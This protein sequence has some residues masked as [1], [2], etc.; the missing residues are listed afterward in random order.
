MMLE[1][2]SLATKGDRGTIVSIGPGIVNTNDFGEK[3]LCR[4]KLENGE[5]TECFNKRFRFASVPKSEPLNDIPGV[6]FKKVAKYSLVIT[7]NR[8]DVADE[9]IEFK[10]KMEE[11][12]D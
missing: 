3:Y 6:S 2:Y 7:T 12:T 8:I 4:I 11:Y 1:D 5:Y 9:I 10:N